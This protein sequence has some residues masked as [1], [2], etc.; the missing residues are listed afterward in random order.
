MIVNITSAGYYISWKY[1]EIPGRVPVEK[2]VVEYMTDGESTRRRRDAD[3]SVLDGN[4]PASHRVYL[5]IAERLDPGVTYDFRMFA[6]GGNSFS[7]AAY[8]TETYRHG[9]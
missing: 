4:I 5:L 6:F 7:D 8:V 9:E 1:N 3:W 2:F